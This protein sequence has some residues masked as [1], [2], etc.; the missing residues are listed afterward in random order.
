VEELGCDVADFVDGLLKCAFGSGGWVLDAGDFADE[1]PGGLFDF[2]F[3]GVDPG[4]LAQA[5]D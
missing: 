5:L 1:L 4:G 3:R 2:V